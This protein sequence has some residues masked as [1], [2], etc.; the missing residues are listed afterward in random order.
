[1]S[2]V[3]DQAF[4]KDQACRGI[5]SNSGLR[6]STEVRSGSLMLVYPY[7]IS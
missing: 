6:G 1:M 3:R 2:G 7:S 5:P 4:V